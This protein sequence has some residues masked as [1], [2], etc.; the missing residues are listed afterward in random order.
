[1]TA[2]GCCSGRANFTAASSGGGAPGSKV[3]V[4]AGDTNADFLASKLAAGDNVALTVVNPGGIETLRIDA[5]SNCVPNAVSARGLYS[6]AENSLTIASGYASHAEG[7]ATRA[8][9]PASNFTISAGGTLVTIAG[10]VRGKFTNGVT[11][12]ITPSAPAVLPTLSRTINSVPAFAAGNT[13]FQISA[14]IDASTVSGSVVEAG[15]TAF[16]RGYTAHAEG[17]LCIAQGAES[18]AEGASCVALGPAAHAEGG[19][20]YALGIQAHAEGE[21]TYAYAVD[22]HAEG[23]STIAGGFCAHAEGGAGATPGPIANGNS[24][25]AEGVSSQT[26]NSLRTFTM[27]AGGTLIT[28]AGNVCHEFSNGGQI[29]LMPQTPSLGATVQATIG[30]V[31]AFAAGN[32]TFNLTVPISAGV[33]LQRP[34][35]GPEFADQIT[36]GLCLQGGISGVGSHAEG[37]ATKAT[38]LVS[39]AE[40]NLGRA[41]GQASHCEGTSTKAFG[42]SSHAEGNTAAAT[43]AEAHA[44]GNTTL[45]NSNSSHVEGSG[46]RAGFPL[47]TFTIAAGG[48]LVTIA[49]VNATA[50]FVNGSQVAIQSTTPT[51]L[52]P[53]LLN[54][55]SVPAFAAGNTTFNLSAAID[56]YVTGGKI[57]TP[58]LGTG[59]HAEGVSSVATGAAAHA[60]GNICVAS[61]ANG[62]HAEGNNTAASGSSSHAEG[63]TTTASGARSH[64]EGTSSV[65]S[66][67]NSH[68]EGNLCTA[69]GSAAHAE[70]NN[71]TASG[72]TSHAQGDSTVA[73]GNRAHAEGTSSQ[74]RNTNAH[75]EGNDCFADGAHSHAQ[76]SQSYAFLDNEHAEAGGQFTA[77]GDNQLRRIQIKGTTPGAAPGETVN[78][79][80]GGA[81][82]NFI[83]SSMAS[84]IRVRAIATKMGLGAAARE[85][86]LFDVELLVSTTSAGALTISAVTPLATILQ[87]AAFVGAT[88]TFTTPGVNSLTVTFSIAGGLTV[89]SRIT[90]SMEVVEVLGT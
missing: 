76:G 11:C 72:T 19:I 78:L 42:A 20:T 2:F 89:A 4:D 79:L 28:I 83:R 64:S 39:H 23:G 33:G 88:L 87:G 27:P 84:A 74:A 52:A 6:C 46:T 21:T 34:V 29:F 7:E 18:H 73:S 38:G 90:A 56:L 71:T 58:G 70:G 50:E 36:G 25:H 49:G 1:M 60:E 69:S 17:A 16:D 67:T 15:Q 65:A 12:R 75:A 61:G 22:A 14:A 24:S 9:M 59:A 35:D 10:D 81:A 66:N 68:A 85:T 62:S 45:A 51:E 47:R 37:A 77:R 80:S 63:D 26:G 5:N 48:V 57:N 54:C 8:G 44:E 31:P 32:T 86:A 82:L 40:G 30:S 13:T 55:A 43:G 41:W 3:S 53:V